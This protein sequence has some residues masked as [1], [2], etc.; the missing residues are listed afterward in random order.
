MI[1]I[2]E[3]IKILNFLLPWI[4][5]E[6]LLYYNDKIIILLKA[7]KKLLK[8]CQITSFI[9]LSKIFNNVLKTI[10]FHLK[11]NIIKN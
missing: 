3:I 11:S 7:K 5:L 4:N 9:I 8:K 1:D 6:C 2:Y 10:V